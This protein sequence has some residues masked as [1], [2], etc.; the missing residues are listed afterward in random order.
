L[1]SLAVPVNTGLAYNIL[2]G[3]NTD[4][5]RPSG[6]WFASTGITANQLP[7]SMRFAEDLEAYGFEVAFD[8]EVEPG[9]YSIFV[10]SATGRRR[11]FIG[12][13]SVENF[14]NYWSAGTVK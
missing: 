13:L 10:E 6:L 14:R 7:G 12:G 9:E 5:P 3:H 4:E 1:A 11:A 2:I 8:A